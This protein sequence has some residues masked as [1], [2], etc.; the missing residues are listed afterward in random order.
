MR[1]YTIVIKWTNRR[2]QDENENWVITSR[3][4]VVRNR[5]KVF[6]QV[7]KGFAAD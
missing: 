1:R 2:V 5:Q 6:L 4:D 3:R 7:L